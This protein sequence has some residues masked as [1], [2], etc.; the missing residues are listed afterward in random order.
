MCTY[1]LYCLN[2]SKLAFKQFGERKQWERWS[3]QLK[4]SACFV[5]HI[6]YLRVCICTMYVP[7]DYGVSEEGISSPK[8]G[9]TESCELPCG[10]WEPI[11]GLLPC[12]LS[13][14]WAIFAAHIYC[15]LFTESSQA[16]PRTIVPCCL[17]VH[18]TGTW[19]TAERLRALVLSTCM[20][21]HN[22]NCI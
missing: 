13:D 15:P 1:Y 14:C 19:E 8:T 20:V 11:W 12:V 21:A 6:L 9:I 7:C 2:Y 22:S 16:L 17:Q 10:D 3:V 4:T 18:C 5:I